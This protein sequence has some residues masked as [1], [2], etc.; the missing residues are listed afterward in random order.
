M[1]KITFTMTQESICE[2][3]GVT[4]SEG[5]DKLLDRLSPHDVTLEDF[6]S[7]INNLIKV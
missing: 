1:E 2:V 3:L 7:T 4:N 6:I 5:L